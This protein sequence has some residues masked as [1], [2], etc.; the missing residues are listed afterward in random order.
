MTTQIDLLNAYNIAVN[1]EELQMTNFSEFKSAVQTYGFSINNFY[2]VIFEINASSPLYGS[3]VKKF[4]KDFKGQQISTTTSLMR[5]YTDEC[6]IPGIQMSTGEY[7]INNSPQLKYAY[8]SVFS[9]TNFSFIM[10]ANSAIKKVFDIWTAFMYG[11][12]VDNN[13]DEDAGLQ[14]LLNTP[15]SSR[16]HRMR[17]RYRD[18]YAIDIIIIKFEKPPSSKKNSRTKGLIPFTK[19]Q[20]IPDYPDAN[21]VSQ[22]TDLEQYSRFYRAIPVHATRLFKAF[23]SNIASIPLNSGASSLNKM[24]VTFEYESYTTSALTGSNSVFGNILDAVNG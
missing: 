5:L 8:G 6:S 14:D 24:S 20:I 3:L 1:N 16:T 7:R 2:D 18:D 10:D 11:Y 17:T 19:K 12:A 21:G 22:Q 9:E 23:P 4:D 15:N 13:V